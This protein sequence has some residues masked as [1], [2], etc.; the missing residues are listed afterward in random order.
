MSSVAN[1]TPSATR[2]DLEA[3]PDDVMGEIIDGVLYTFPRPRP[4]HAYVQTTLASDLDA[5]QRGRPGGWWILV[6]PG[7][8]LEGS[9]EVV[10][11]LA[12]WRRER[13][14][15]LPEDQ[16]IQVVPDW[17]CEI[18]SPTTRGHDQLIKR[19][20][21]ARVG[22]QHLWFIDPEVRTLSVCKLIDGRWSELGVYGA[23]EVIHA[24][25]F[26]AIAL[27]LTGWWPVKRETK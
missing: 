21:Y 3:L 24:E 23:H 11:D 18:L 25:P 6:E 17:V 12:G 8:E 20:F 22:V 9:P 26:Q 27:D 14:P 5:F 10:P 4:R 7:L 19:R 1:A 16:S 13:I 2:A 15:E